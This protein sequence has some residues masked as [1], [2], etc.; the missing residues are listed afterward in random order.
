MKQPEPKPGITEAEWTLMEA[1]W[2][3]SPQTASEVA[4]SLHPS[5]G[6]AVNTVRT[7]LARLGEKRAVVAGE[8]EAGVRVFSPAWEREVM[9]RMES[10]SFL[11]RVF[12]GSAQ[13]LLVHFA[14]RSNLSA[15][16]IDQL[17]QLLDESVKKQAR[18]KS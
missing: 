12:Q 18:R 7:M 14:S 3:R 8:N 1:L 13:P 6:W 4:K 15:A 9:V 16:E 5:T 17:K 11:K 2:E 10:E